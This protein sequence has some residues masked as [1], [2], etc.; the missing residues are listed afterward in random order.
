MVPMGLKNPGKIPYPGKLSFLANPAVRP[1]MSYCRHASS[2]RLSTIHKH[3]ISS[4]IS[5]RISIPIRLQARYLVLPQNLVLCLWKFCFVNNL[6]TSLFILRHFTKIV[7]PPSFLNKFPFR[8]ICR[9]DVSTR[10]NICHFVDQN[11]TL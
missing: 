9:F 2:V 1:G 6:L 8:L 4:L 10:H 5:Q 7:S 3:C 11:L